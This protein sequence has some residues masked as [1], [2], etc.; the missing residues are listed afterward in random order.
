MQFRRRPSTPIAPSTSIPTSVLQTWTEDIERARISVEVQGMAV[1]VVHRGKI[2]YAKGFGKRNDVD[3]FTPETLMPIASIT[4]SFTAAAVGEL[5]GDNKAKWEGVP[6]SEYLP[7]FQGLPVLDLHWYHRLEPRIELIKQ[8]RHV[9]AEAPLRSEYIYN[10]VMVSVA[11][12]AAA[13]IAG[14]TYEQLVLDRVVRPVGMAETGF[15]NVTLQTRPNHALPYMCK[16]FRD[17]QMGCNHRFP[18][19]TLPKSDAPAGD[20]HSNVIELANWARVMMHDGELD[21]KQVLNKESIQTIKTAYTI[22]SR[23][24]RGPEF[25]I[26]A[27]GLCWGIEHYK[28]RPTVQH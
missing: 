18:L 28:G 13:R 14:T 8:M 19:D 25:S 22:T 16:S 6:V 27:Y 23:A 21:G 4:K 17:A 15:S 5:V 20:L 10:N 3:P 1:A 9:D 11:G 12:E 26:G 24:P 2:I 7:E